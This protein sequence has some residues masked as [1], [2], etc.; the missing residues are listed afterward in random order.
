MPFWSFTNQNGRIPN[1]NSIVTDF[2]AFTEFN[3]SEASVFDHEFGVSLSGS[4]T[5]EIDG[6][7]S[8]AYGRFRW[9]KLQLSVG[10]RYEDIQFDNL[11]ATNGN[12]FLSNNARPIPRISIGTQD[13]WKLPYIGDWV[14]VEGRF[15]D[16]IILDDRYVDKTRVH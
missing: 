14:F 12:L 3:H 4:V 13:Y 16:G 2:S 7:I 10:S 15:S 1:E 11:S 8:Q 9:K 6:M 5:N